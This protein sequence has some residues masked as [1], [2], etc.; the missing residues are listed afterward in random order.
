[1]VK[2]SISLAHDTPEA[3]AN[4][5]AVE[6][7]AAVEKELQDKVAT[8]D[9][10]AT[11]PADQVPGVVKQSLDEAHKDPE[12]AANNAAVEEKKQFEEELQKKVAPTDKAGEPA[13]TSSAAATAAAPGVTAISQPAVDSANISPRTTTPAQQ[14]Q[15]QTQPT[16]TTGVAGGPTAQTSQPVGSPSQENS[17]D[18]KKK[19]RASGFFQKLKEKLK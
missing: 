9:G 16:V 4:A 5:E 14:T 15:T 2:Q 3:A 10:P 11:L 8:T 13:P 12:A 19:N 7:K 18:K 1:V 6:E 17:K